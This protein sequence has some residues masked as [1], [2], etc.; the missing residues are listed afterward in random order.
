MVFGVSD[1]ATRQMSPLLS[2]WEMHP[3]DES[4]LLHVRASSVCTMSDV[5]KRSDCILVYG[6]TTRGDVVKTSDCI[7]VYGSTTKGGVVKRSDCILVYGST[8][9]GGVVKRSDCIPVLGTLRYSL[10]IV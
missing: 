8:T 4:A 5:M 6:S 2:L 7:L 1:S 3:Q 10:F 9:K